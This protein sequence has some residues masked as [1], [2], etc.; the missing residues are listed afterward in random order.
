MSCARLNISKNNDRFAGTPVRRE[1]P[2]S[3]YSAKTAGDCRDNA[4]MKSMKAGGVFETVKN[5]FE[6]R[7]K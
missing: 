4:C 6:G 5:V 7:G 2:C 3:P 1:M